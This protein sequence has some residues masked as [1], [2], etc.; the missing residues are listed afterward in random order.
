MF[1]L[2]STLPSETI[3]SSSN[4]RLLFIMVIPSP[5]SKLSVGICFVGMIVLLSCTEVFDDHSV[6]VDGGIIETEM[7]AD[8]ARRSLT[9][10]YI[11]QVLIHPIYATPPTL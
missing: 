9:C 6:V 7:N 10:L 3:T 1:T 4:P 8:G 11:L 2:D 5:P